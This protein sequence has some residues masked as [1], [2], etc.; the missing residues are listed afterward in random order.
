MQNIAKEYDHRRIEAKGIENWDDSLYY[1][2]WESD[3]APYIIDT[4][5][6]YPTGS[7]HIGNALNWCY[8][9]FI[10]RYR[11]MQGYNVM[12]PQGW[13]CHG[14]PTEVKVEE[15]HEIT[16]SGLDR[17][18]FRR[19]CCELTS[20]NIEKMRNTMK[21][22]GL[23]IDW[24][25][26][27]ITMDPAYYRK[28]QV[29]FVRMYEKGLIYRDDHPVNWCPRCKTAIAF[30]EV[31]YDTRETSLN[32]IHFEGVDIATTRPELIPAC[33]AVAVNPDDERFTDLIGKEVGVPIFDYHVPVI[34]DPEVDSTFGTGIVMICTFGDKQDV[35]WWKEHSLPLR[36]AIDRDGV[37]TE[38]AGR[39]AGMKIKE[40][41]DAIIE[42]LKRLGLLYESERIEQNVGLCWRCKTPIEILSERQW[43][44][45]I[46]QEKVLD[47]AAKIEWIPDYMI[48]RLKNWVESM[49]WD[50]CISRQ[51][52]FATPIPVWYCKA[53]GKALVAR[54]AELPVDPTIDL[55]EETCSCGSNEFEGETD[56]L[57]TWMDSSISALV[58]GGWLEDK[59]IFPTQLRP[60]GHDII[61]TWAFY[62][63]LRSIALT[64]K[65]PWETIVINGMVLGEDGHKMSK[66]R[67]NIT[68]PEAVMEKYGADAF[69]QWAAIGGS[70]GS[71]VMFRWK[72]IVAASRFLQKL[73]SI[74][75]F[76]L[77]HIDKEKAPYKK[78]E[79]LRATDRWLLARLN[80]LIETVTAKMDAYS[81]DEA[82]KEIR[83]F[84]W[85]IL[86]DDYIELVK[87]RLYSA[88]SDGSESAI[89]TL[90]TTMETL[91][92][93]IAPFMP[94]FAE[95][96]HS[97][98]AAESVHAK[99]WPVVNYDLIDERSLEEGEL[100]RKIVEAVR[101]YKSENKIPLNAPLKNIEIYTTLD[102][103][104]DDIKGTL[105]SEV[106]IVSPTTTLNMKAV[107]I[108]P[109]MDVIGPMYRKQAGE[110]AKRL[111]ELDAE[112]VEQLISEGKK[113][114]IE[115]AGDHIVLDDSSF[116][117]EHAFE[118]RGERVDLLEVS[119]IK[120][121]VA[122]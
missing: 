117:I 57:D 26:E 47:A 42:D 59:F 44:V 108:K 74:L 15:T 56:V 72:D 34:A 29:S 60:Q 93:L 111:R 17:I 27:Y 8:I 53:C 103:D 119:G 22:L 107:S 88:N 2:D 21:S 90:Y 33:V 51:R 71:D 12:F 14:L 77:I 9:D 80:M 98:L 112:E 25:N 118:S 110:I 79:Q 36:R 78:P 115:V 6:P 63:I 35:R 96:M 48:I 49:E 64:D 73:W 32:Y 20:S 91:S 109:R 99:D 11:R 122:R 82:M 5:P 66:S 40:T 95:E 54:E 121:A 84:T 46:E 113:V 4:P 76:S 41:R 92:R 23:S 28:T 1:F 87:S 94:F 81:F 102:L 61:R 13:D 67:N 18:E 120:S 50:W 37:M 55:P 69:R 58:V 7:F 39:Y 62:T 70:T 45:R 100:I 85:N 24:S 3:K 75:R 116:E 83:G 52:L 89:Y 19:L 106:E 31:E 30:A 68:A 114:E 43:F 16:K 97:Y 38:I 104:V 10:A 65:I 101:R 86:A 105:N